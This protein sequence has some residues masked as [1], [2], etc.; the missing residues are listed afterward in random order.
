MARETY[1]SVF[2][3]SQSRACAGAFVQ[4]EPRPHVTAGAGRWEVQDEKRVQVSSSV[5]RRQSA[6]CYRNR[7][8][9]MWT[10]AHSEAA[11]CPSDGSQRPPHSLTHAAALED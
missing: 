5:G 1:C 2:L 7:G 11:P 10:R 6:G 9:P 4:K 8:G 3:S